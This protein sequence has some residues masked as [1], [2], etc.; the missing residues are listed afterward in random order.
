MNHPSQLLRRI[1]RQQA[2]DL[3]PRR[4]AV[5]PMP[6]PAPI[7]PAPAAKA[8]EVPSPQAPAQGTTPAPALRRQKGHALYSQVMRSHD[9]MGT[10]HL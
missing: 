2:R 5:A 10:R 8:P 1:H 7:A 4:D 9:R 3:A 6:A